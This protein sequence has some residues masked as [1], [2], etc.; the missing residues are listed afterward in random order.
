MAIISLA[1]GVANIMPFPPLDGGKMVIV[2]GEA[3]T[4]KKMP[5]NVEAILSYIGLGLL[6]LLTIF[7]TY[8]DIVRIF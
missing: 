4:R 3:I 2:I 5:L 7:V 6:I 8:N 1:V